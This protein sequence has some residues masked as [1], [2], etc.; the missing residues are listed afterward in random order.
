MNVTKI[1]SGGQ[2]GADRA[3]LDFAMENGIETGG[4]IPKG[5]VAE[6]GQIPARY[7]N[8]IETATSDPSE[9]TVLNVRHSD[10]T[11]IL[12][13]GDLS[14]G[15]KLTEKFAIELDKPLLHI[16]LLKHSH[17]GA[18]SVTRK[19]LAD[20]NCKTLNLAGPRA[21][22]APEIYG[23]SIEFLRVLFAHRV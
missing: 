17:D 14:G 23:S 1:I 16:D 5:R 21:S 4:H 6:D 12:S 8:L 22:E 18:A 7:P 19:W 11:L 3:A 2:T 13:H 20:T 10:A 9:R 15:S